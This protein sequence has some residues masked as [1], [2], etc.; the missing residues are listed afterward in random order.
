MSF[1]IKRSKLYRDDQA[2]EFVRSPY[3]G[4]AFSSKPKILV[5][6]F[7]SGGSARSSAKW[8][9]NPDNPGSSA[10]LIIDRDGLVLQC[11]NL[12][13]IAWHAGRS[14]WT[15]IQGK[16]MVGL[17]QFSLGIE[18]ANWGHLRQTQD[19]WTS[20]TGVKIANPVLAVHKNGNPLGPRH[21]PAGWEAYPDV[22]FQA[23]VQIART[24]VN[25]LDI[26]EIVGHD[27]IAPTR[28]W[29]PGPAFDMRRFRGLVFGGRNNDGDNHY[30]VSVK[31]GL[32]LRRGPGIQFDAITLLAQGTSLDPIETDGNWLNVSVLDKN[33]Q[34]QFTGWVNS[35]YIKT[36]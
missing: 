1:T 27:D 32:N 21:Q 2:I 14:Q 19:G 13:T 36:A 26:D 35:H 29:D 28:K 9:K 20:Y 4:G 15:N 31:A 22:Q 8:F 6:H 17:N 18:L 5:I 23:A 10:H 30:I 3:T 16:N 33:N 24:M 12:D 7:T 11:V 34:P 25:T